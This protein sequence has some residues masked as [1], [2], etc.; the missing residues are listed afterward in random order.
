MGQGA[1]I[2]LGTAVSVV[3]LALAAAAPAG[4]AD[5][6]APQHN[7]HQPDDGWQAG[8]CTLDAGPCSV[9]TRV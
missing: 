6:I 5:I 9:D 7:P 4:A 3:L 2:W 8:T 1:R